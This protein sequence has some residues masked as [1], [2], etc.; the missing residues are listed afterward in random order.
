MSYTQGVKEGG[1]PPAYTPEDEDVHAKVAI[2][3][4]RHPGHANISDTCKEFCASLLVGEYVPSELL[5]T[6]GLS[7]L[8]H[9]TEEI[10]VQWTKCI[11]LAGHRPQP[12]FAVRII[13][14]MFSEDEIEKLR[15]YTV[16]GKSALFMGNLYFPFHTC[17]VKRGEN[18][19][20]IAD[21]QNTHSASMAINAIVQ[22]YRTELRKK[23]LHQQILVLSI[24]HDHTM[25][26]ICGHYPLINGEKT[27]FRR[28]TVRSFGFTEQ[29]GKEKYT[30]YNFA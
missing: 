6:R 25:V 19:L 10:S 30:A 18:G 2:F 5:C 9:L 21:R 20:N 4:Y 7:H 1:N 12:D 24:S 16:P 11:S 27:I 26:K 23:G 3:I 22:L 8:K 29:E 28:Y 15:Y 13:S 17:E 14:S